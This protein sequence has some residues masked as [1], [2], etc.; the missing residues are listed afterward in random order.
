MHLNLFIQ[1]ALAAA[2]LLWVPWL[3][4]Q[5]SISCRKIFL[6]APLSGS[7][8]LLCEPQSPVGIL[9]GGIWFLWCVANL[10][11]TLKQSLMW[12]HDHYGHF[13]NGIASVLLVGGATWFMAGRFEATFLGFSEPWKT[14]TAIHFHYSG[15]LLTA[16]WGIHWTKIN[17]GC[18][19]VVRRSF[20]GATLSYIMGFVLIA[21]GINGIRSSELIGVAVLFLAI[22]AIATLILRAHW[23]TLTKK[24]KLLGFLIAIV[25]SIS[26]SL[27]TLYSW[28]LT[29]GLDLPMM[30]SSHGL[31]NAFVFMPI[32]LL[33]SQINTHAL[34]VRKIPF[35]RLKSVWRVGPGFFDKYKVS[36]QTK[37]GLLDSFSEFNRVDFDSARVHSQVRLFYERTID[38]DLFVTA[39]PH[40]LFVNVWRWI[41]KPFFSSIQ[42]LNLPDR[43]KHIHG[44]IQ[45][46]QANLDGR[47]SPRGWMRTDVAT[48]RSIYAAAYSMHE[49]LGIK[50]MNIAFPMPFSNMTS[51]LHIGHLKSRFADGIRLTTLKE[52]NTL[53]D[54]GVFFVIGNWAIRI[55]LDETIDVWFDEHLKASHQMWFG[56]WSY[57]TLEYE[58]RHL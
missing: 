42:Q 22:S 46:V 48:G 4:A 28:R 5:S 12:G 37:T 35:S 6:L 38:Y 33:F 10:V 16:I 57:L 7:S 3:K 19:P 41:A 56:G 39:H 8:S 1:V 36:D 15:F 26:F 47:S 52:E 2:I 27:A 54:Q 51:V 25:G 9:L 53:G 29:P 55:P 20:V 14:L 50:Y 24:N 58:I 34:P 21:L 11:S 45:S 23:P 13:L 31:L 18:S 30:I 17:M 44:Q 43:T 49:A 32:L 40:R